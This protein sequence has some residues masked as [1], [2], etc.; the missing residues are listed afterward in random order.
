MCRF[1]CL[2][3]SCEAWVWFHAE[4]FWHV[5]FCF[6]A[7]GMAGMSWFLILVLLII[8]VIIHLNIRSSALWQSL[9]CR[10]PE[11]VVL[12]YL[13]A[14]SWSGDYKESWL[15]DTLIHLLFLSGCLCNCSG[16][17]NAKQDILKCR[18][19]IICSYCYW[20]VQSVCCHGAVETTQWH[21]WEVKR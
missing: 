6:Q 17:R 9:C 21:Y 18:C 7:G 12:L 5:I 2:W 14:L 19:F 8:H 3:R 1:V 4:I 13:W 11:G 16:E 20:T 10:Q 15:K